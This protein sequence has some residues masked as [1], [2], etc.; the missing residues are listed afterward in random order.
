MQK[1]TKDNFEFLQ[2]FNYINKETKSKL[3]RNIVD[4]IGVYAE[5]RYLVVAT[6]DGII[7]VINIRNCQ[8]IA[9]CATEAKQK[10]TCMVMASN[11]KTVV[12]ATGEHWAYMIKD[13]H[14]TDGNSPTVCHKLMGHADKVLAVTATPDGKFAITGSYDGCI[15]YWNTNT[16]EC[17]KVFN[18]YKS[19]ICAIT[20]TPDGKKIITGD[21]RGIVSV[22]NFETTAHEGSL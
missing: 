20:I 4:L 2:L 22:Y 10:I 11:L 17:E 14:N 1:Q 15:I 13:I 8:W 6:D 12:F 3:P 9:T 16:G 7:V 5:Q 19:C 21:T 18:G